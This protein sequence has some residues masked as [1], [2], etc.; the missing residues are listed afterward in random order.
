MGEASE[1]RIASGSTQNS[2]HLFIP[3]DTAPGLPSTLPRP[4]TA[5]EEQSGNAHEGTA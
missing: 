2:Q 3:Q 1:Y 4:S 5:A